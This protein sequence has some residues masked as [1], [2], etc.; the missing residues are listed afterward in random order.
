MSQR[1]I[2]NAMIA[3]AVVAVIVI[4]CVIYIPQK[5]KAST[6]LPHAVTINTK[7]QPMMGSPNAKLRIVA[8][9]DLKCSNCMRYNTTVFPEVYNHYIKTGIANYTMITLAFIPG[10]MPAANAARCI[11][12]QNKTAYWDFVKYVYNNQPPE[13]ENWAT[14]PNLMLMA[15]H[16]KGINNDKLA[17]CLV[18]SPYTDLIENN[19]K[20]LQSIMKPPVGTP[21]VYINGVRVDPL[22]WDNVK[23]VA[24]EVQ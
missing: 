15:S 14:I 7:N 5:D 11:Y 20:L 21:T 3:I 12:A 13:E 23:Q 4:L 18:K 16:L 9:E 8:F 24:S 1:T 17:Q 10:S 6:T 22:T 2:R 19:L